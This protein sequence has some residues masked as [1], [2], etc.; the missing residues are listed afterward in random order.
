MNI[1]RWLHNYKVNFTSQSIS[2]FGELV[3][4]IL[5]LFS[6]LEYLYIFIV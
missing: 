5:L 3:D 2:E 4:C 6:L 1:G